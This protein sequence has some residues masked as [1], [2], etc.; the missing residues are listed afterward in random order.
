MPPK[1]KL[2]PEQKKERD[3][4]R[5]ANL[6]RISRDT[7]RAGQDIAPLP[8][9]ADGE[10][11]T[12][13]LND[14]YA[15]A[16]FYFPSHFTDE[17][18]VAHRYNID[19]I[20][21]SLGDLRH[22][23]NLPRGYGKTTAMIAVILWLILRGE[24]RYA[25][26][27]SASEDNAK[28][29]VEKFLGELESNKTLLADFPDVCFP[30]VTLE[31]ETRRALGQRL[32]GVRT[33]LQMSADMIRFPLVSGSP[34]SG[35][36][37][38]SNGITSKTL[39]TNK[40]GVGNEGLMRPDFIWMDDIQDEESSESYT[41]TEKIKKKIQKTFKFLTD[42]KKPVKIVITCTVRNR[43]DIADQYLKNPRWSG[44][45]C[46][47]LDEMP[48]DLTA[49]R[50]Y[51]EYHEKL[52]EQYQTHE[53]P[54][55]RENIVRKNLNEY[56]QIH[57]QELED[58]F[59]PHWEY[60]KKPFHLSAIQSAMEFWLED[61]TSFWSEL[62]NK[63]LAELLQDTDDLDVDKIMAK[64][65]PYP[66]DWIPPST[67][68][69]VAAIDIH[70]EMLSYLVLSGGNSFSTHLCDY[71]IYPEQTSRAV[72][73]PE[74]VARPISMVYHGY[75]T[76]DAVYTAVDELV[77]MLMQKRFERDDGTTKRISRILIDAK[78]GPL[79]ATIRKYCKNTR[80]P[81]V[82]IHSFSA[83]EDI[84]NRKK[85]LGEKRDPSGRW[86]IPPAANRGDP[87][88]I[89]YDGNHW[90]TFALARILSP[91]G[92]RSTLTLYEGDRTY[93]AQLISD[94]TAETHEKVYTKT[95][96]KDVIQTKWRDK[97]GK[98]NRSHLWDCVTMCFVAL[99][100]QGFAIESQ[101]KAKTTG[102]REVKRWSSTDRSNRET[103]RNF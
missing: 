7:I 40:R 93:H 63:P 27:V 95:A 48:K 3:V 11:R 47:A 82:V 18:S 55:E 92:N 60:A 50:N 84:Y 91:M 5:K 85:K 42:K 31:H 103:F 2:T 53:P 46:S 4:A 56:Y 43:D 29:I 24:I 81:D 45:R 17:F 23:F 51:G 67:E 26:I 99:S 88:H 22:I 33:E 66:R 80:Y 61:E 90:K 62:M 73:Q 97:P 94:W 58:G 16:A 34:A 101:E 54:E 68:A 78:Y 44:R 77:E 102:R 89:L 21:H 65:L 9:I 12:R 98:V 37:I 36:I 100:E 30:F 25:Y 71:G 1:L 52:L 15:F 86:V 74:H 64:R 10:R 19:I 72:V 20:T 41:Q 35:A 83:T 8:L 32:N 87:R 39:G 14:F 49:W 38:K 6:A 75:E 79:T 70:N 96:R 76:E 59:K 57:R 28:E 69:V 13:M